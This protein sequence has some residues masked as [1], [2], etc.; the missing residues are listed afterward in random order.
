M[1]K[2]L[3]RLFV[4]FLSATILIACNKDTDV[5]DSAA[6]WV[7]QTSISVFSQAQTIKL[8]IKFEGETP[9][10]TSAKWLTVSIVSEQGDNYLVI[11]IPENESTNA[12]RDGLIYLT[13]GNSTASVSI[14]QSRLGQLEIKS[15]NVVDVPA[16]ATDLSLIVKSNIE[17]KVIIPEKAKDWINYNQDNSK[18]SIFVFSIAENTDSLRCRSTYVVFENVDGKCKDSIKVYQNNTWGSLRTAMK[19][20]T[21]AKLFYKALVATHMIDS[22]SKIIDDSYPVTGYDS[23]LL[24]YLLTGMSAIQIK[25][26]YEHDFA[27]IPDSRYFRYSVFLVPDMVFE[28]YDIY[29]FDDL[30]QYAHSVYGDENSYDDMTS[31]DNS[32]NKLISYHIVPQNIR[33]L[34]Y[35][36]HDITDNYIGWPIQDI[37]NYCETLMPHSLISISIPYMDKAKK[38]INRYSNPN[39][40]TFHNGTKIKESEYD[41]DYALNGTV[42]YLDDL[43]LYDNF[44]RETIFNK[45]IRVMGQTL[46]PDFSNSGASGRYGGKGQAYA[47]SDRYVVTFRNGY[48]KNFSWTNGTELYVR[49]ADATFPIYMGNDLIISGNSDIEFKLPSVPNNGTYEI[50]YFVNSMAYAGP[51]GHR[52]TVQF[53]YREGDDG[54]WKTCGNPYQLGRSG[55]DPAIGNITDADLAK[56]IIDDEAKEQVIKDHDNAMRQRGYMKAPAS[57]RQYSSGK[58]LRDDIDCY[59]IILCKE[60]MS[61]NED[62]YLRIKKMDSD[63]ESVIPLNFI[64]IV[65]LSIAESGQEDKY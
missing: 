65:P 37:E 47:T 32:L 41:M 23:S 24:N 1:V 64:E 56:N 11:D 45:R 31:R 22:I 50:R 8:K 33:P 53:Y 49:Y 51:I 43:L 58:I 38:Y 9:T 6:I 39:V 63:Y 28:N 20:H 62:H 40:G 59:R 19:E 13:S 36:H 35:P 30:R 16:N 26:D 17:V 46:S 48:C 34:Y 61:A 55:D 21:D 10:F 4:A 29:S 18:D 52:A 57:Y 44:T 14:H 42:Y 15:E 2:S 25:V 7:E 54:A 27:I 3:Y 12:D 5:A 60:Q